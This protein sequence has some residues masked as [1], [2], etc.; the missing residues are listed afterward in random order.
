ML[1]EI[2]NE[3][4]GKMKITLEMLRKEYASLRA[5]RA[6]PSILD[7]ITVD[8][9]GTPTPLMQ[10]ANISAPEPRLLLIQPWDKTSIPNIEKAILKSDLGINPSNDGSVIRIAVPQLTEERRQELVKVVHK[11]AEESR[12]STRNVRRDYNDKVKAQEKAKTVTEDEA[13]KGLEDI[14]KMTDKYI[15]EIDRVADLK[16][17]EIMEV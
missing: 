14:Q 12:V 13:K 17:K 2:I 3:C 8:Y 9:Y 7:R 11:K 4:E 16:E 6:N 1:K 5:G 10:M 15:K